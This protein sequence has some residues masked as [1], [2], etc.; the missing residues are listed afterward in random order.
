MDSY[1]TMKPD[2]LGDEADNADL[3]AFRRACVLH[4]RMQHS[5]DMATTEYM[6]NDGEWGVRVAEYVDVEPLSIGV[7]TELQLMHAYTTGGY[8]L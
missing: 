7:E 3:A 8:D 1:K 5:T 4:Q 2:D 6:W